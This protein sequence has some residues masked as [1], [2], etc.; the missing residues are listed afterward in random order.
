MA[1]A[2]RNARVAS[3]SISVP[4]YTIVYTVPANTV[5]LLKHFTIHLFDNAAQIQQVLLT[6]SDAPNS[7]V[8]AAQ[9]IAAQSYWTW[10]GW[11]ALNAGD[12]IQINMAGAGIRYWFSGALLPFNPT[13]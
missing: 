6:P 11:I 8:V 13:L 2:I 5:L 1:G 10:S 12:E 7:L 9:S 3:G 4:G